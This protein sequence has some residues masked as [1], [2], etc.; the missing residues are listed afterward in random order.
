MDQGIAFDFCLSKEPPIQP[1]K[2]L[3]SYYQRAS[4]SHRS[5]HLSLIPVLL[6][7]REALATKN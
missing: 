1:L 5:K 6:L 3:V 7:L 2:P 4:I